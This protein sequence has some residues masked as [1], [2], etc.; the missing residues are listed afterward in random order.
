MRRQIQVFARVA[1]L[2]LVLMF[3]SCEPSSKEEYISMFNEFVTEIEEKHQ[4]FGDSK[5]SIQ[6][7]KYDKLS[8]EWYYKFKDELSSSEKFSIKKLQAEFLYYYNMHKAGSMINDAIDAIQETDIKKEINDA[9]N[10]SD[11]EKEINDVAKELGD[12]TEEGGELLEGIIEK[13][14]DATQEILKAA[15]DAMK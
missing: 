8:K 14:N 5:W 2:S 12:L 1:L 15:E 10:K 11:L 6:K 4:E 13:A 9:I 3:V 7:E